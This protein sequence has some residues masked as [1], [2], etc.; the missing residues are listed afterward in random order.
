M[1]IE[2]PSLRLPG[3]LFTMDGVEFHGRLSFLKAGIALADA[4]T[5]VSPS[6]AR[7]IQ[8][9]EHGC[10]LDGLL[11]KDSLL[12]VQEDGYQNHEDE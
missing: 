1:F 10:G 8:T 5:T 2:A 12:Q 4:L 9:P 7:E 6:Y 11:R 3:S